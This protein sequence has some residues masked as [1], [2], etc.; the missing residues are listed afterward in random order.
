MKTYVYI[1]KGH[2]DHEGF[3]IIGVYATQA[4]AAGVVGSTQYQP[5]DYG[6]CGGYDRISI[7]ALPVQ[8]EK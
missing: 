3:A 4:L 1:V 2:W 5:D 7:V 6:S 8:T